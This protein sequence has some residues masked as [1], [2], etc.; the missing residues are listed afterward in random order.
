MGSKIDHVE[1]PNCGRPAKR[2][3]WEESDDEIKCPHCDWDNSYGVFFPP[4]AEIIWKWEDVQSLRPDWTPYRCQQALR[5]FGKRLKEMSVQFGHGV[6]ED[7]LL[8]YSGEIEQAEKT[9]YRSTEDN[10]QT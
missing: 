3:K 9:E 10:A 5:L 1:C 2:E 4:K 8:A 6:I 7:L